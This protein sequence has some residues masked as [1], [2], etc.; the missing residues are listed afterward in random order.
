MNPGRR[1]AAER[2]SR[3]MTQTKLANLVGMSQGALSLLESGDSKEPEG[4]TLMRV[5]RVL[6]L[7]PEWVMFGRGEKYL[8]FEMIERFAALSENDREIVIQMMDRLTPKLEI[9]EEKTKAS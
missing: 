1:I 3:H 6:R 2:K 5:C 7:N 8:D 9:K 4:E